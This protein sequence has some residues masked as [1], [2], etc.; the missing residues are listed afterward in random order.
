MGSARCFSVSTA[1]ALHTACVP[2][3]RGLMS[4]PKARLT[5]TNVFGGEMRY[6][7]CLIWMVKRSGSPAPGLTQARGETVE[8]AERS[9]RVFHRRTFR[10]F[11]FPVN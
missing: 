6:L 8:D 3:T 2:T 11:Q 1:E 10:A 9:F 4:W 5:S 7:R